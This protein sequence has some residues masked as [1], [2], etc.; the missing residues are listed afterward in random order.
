VTPVEVAAA[1]TVFANHGVY[2][3][4]H[5]IKYIRDDRGQRVHEYKP[6]QRQVLDPRVA[7]MMVN[8]MEEVLRSGTG[9]GV[10]ARGFTLPAAGKT[11]TSH[12]GWFVGFTSHLICAVW[13]GFDD[14]RE[15]TLEGARSALPIW[16][17]FMKRAHTFR[18]YR[19]P[20]PFPAP[21]GIVTVDIDPE[22]GQLASGMCPRT[23]GE[24]FL[25]GTQPVEPCI[26][27][28]GGGTHVASWDVPSAH[29]VPGS[30]ISPPSLNSPSGGV[31][32]A[33]VAVR[34]RPPEPR[35]DGTKEPA[36]VEKPAEKK[37]GFFGRIRDIF[38]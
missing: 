37:R 27:H 35:D 18:E 13:V 14:N 6:K 38:R 2:V 4:P 17:E 25:A 32:P 9:A 12:D 26:T 8:M 20:R 5:Y 1:Y 29:P 36:E 16:T 30:A 10:R 24:V 7:F 34:S 22:T 3:Q 21:E 31:P 33:T 19:N 11:G 15:L 23:R 28:G